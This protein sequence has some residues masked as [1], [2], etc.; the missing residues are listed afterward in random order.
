MDEIN[1]NRDVLGIIFSFLPAEYAK[2]CTLCKGIK[3][4]LRDAGIDGWDALI[5]QGCDIKITRDTIIW[6]KHGKH[7]SIRDIP[8]V[9]GKGYRK[10]YQNGVLH[11]YTGPALINTA[12]M[13]SYWY[14]NGIPHRDDGPA[15]IMTGFGSTS[16]KYVKNGM[17]HRYEL[18]AVVSIVG[19]GIKNVQFWINDRL[20]RGGDI[21]KIGNCFTKIDK[22]GSYIV[23]C[24][25]F[26]P[27]EFF[28][29]E[30]ARVNDDIST[31]SM[32]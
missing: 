22:N 21:F 19:V 6:T 28:D 30:I 1:L 16:V 27:D 8:A 9:V 7:N 5:A 3:T 12:A 29:R 32:E 4:L 23:N 24:D 18:P 26:P 20:V 13:S 31:W 11:R 10:W 15:V 25:Y 14:K 17:L 2:L